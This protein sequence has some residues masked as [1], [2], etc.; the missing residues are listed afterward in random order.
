MALWLHFPRYTKMLP[1][2][3]YSA[4]LNGV[5][6]TVISIHVAIHFRPKKTTNFR[7]V[8]APAVKPKSANFIC[9]SNDASI[10]TICCVRYWKFPFLLNRWKNHLRQ[11]RQHNQWFVTLPIEECKPLKRLNRA[12]NNLT[13]TLR[14]E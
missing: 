5:F 11:I 7:K 4:T 14:Q 13:T 8:F 9:L 1:K 3:R 6:V 12:R 2:L 10:Q